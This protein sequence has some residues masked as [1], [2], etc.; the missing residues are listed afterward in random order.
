M[1]NGLTWNGK[2]ARII[3]TGELVEVISYD[4]TSLQVKMPKGY[5][6]S[7][8]KDEVQPAIA[9]QEIGVLREVR[10]LKNKLEQTEA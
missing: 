9:A 10:L 2:Y 8:S 7:V 4:A 5:T 3:K 1:N 6:A